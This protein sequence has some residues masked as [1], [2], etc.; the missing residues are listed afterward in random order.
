MSGYFGGKQAWVVGGTQ[1]IGLALAEQLRALGAE[2]TLLARN[3]ASLEAQG[4]RLGAQ[5]LALDVA[6]GPATLRTLEDRVEHHGPPDFLF[7]CAGLALPG[8]L[9][10]LSLE[11]ITTMNQVNYLGTVHTCK[12]VLPAMLARGRGHILNTSSLGG[13]MGLFGYTAYCASKYAVIGF[14]EA[15]RREVADGGLRVSVLCPPNTRT[16]GLEQENLRKPP[17]VLAQEEQVSVLEPGQVASYTLRQM[18]R[19]PTLIIPSMDGR[20]A[21]RLARFAPAILH[22]FLRRPRAK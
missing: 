7:N 6:D 1:G 3:Q 2:V 14:S 9:E 17:E 12:A 16:P 19:N 11:D 10:D 5:W 18:P 13:L 21:H 15:L 22:L 20:W 8:Y 4:Q